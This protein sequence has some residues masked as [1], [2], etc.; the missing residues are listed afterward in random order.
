MVMLL[1]MAAVPVRET[2]YPARAARLFVEETQQEKGFRRSQTPP[3]KLCRRGRA[4]IY[5][6]SPSI[7]QASRKKTRTNEGQGRTRII[8]REEPAPPTGKSGLAQ[9]RKAAM[10][11]R[12]KS[13][14]KKGDGHKK[15]KRA[16]RSNGPLPRL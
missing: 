12:K 10:N 9:S 15:H 14:M 3:G 11:R 5:R 4:P 7:R 16:Q 6:N 2:T 8:H 13:G 1:L